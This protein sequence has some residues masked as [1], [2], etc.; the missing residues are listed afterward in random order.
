M[1]TADV[2]I[3]VADLA[4]PS[5][6]A[7]L[8]ALLDAYARDPMGGGAPLAPA[9]AAVLPERLAAQPNARIWLACAPDGTPVGIAVCF[10]GFSTFAA[11]PLLNVHDLAVLPAHRGRGI[12]RRLLETV[13]AAAR[14]MGC[15]KVTLEVR[16]DN[17]TAQ[18]LYAA[19]GYGGAW[20]F[21]SRQF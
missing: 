6:R 14:A 10:V 2:T 15:C 20:R 3:R 12:G 1:S 17:A 18:G 4:Q 7:A 13:E 9:V 8:V 5:D 11:Q 21:W 16:D 19:L